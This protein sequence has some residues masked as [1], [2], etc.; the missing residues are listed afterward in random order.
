MVV[1]GSSNRYAFPFRYG[2]EKLGKESLDVASRWKHSLFRVR[3]RY[4]GHFRLM[5]KTLEVFTGGFRQL[6]ALP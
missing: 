2:S 5:Y 1:D 6:A 4:R 3:I